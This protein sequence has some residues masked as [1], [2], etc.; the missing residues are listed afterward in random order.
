M[1]Y[2]GLTK[3]AA[4]HFSSVPLAQ[5]SQAVTGDSELFVCNLFPGELLTPVNEKDGST[6]FYDKAGELVAV[7][8]SDGNVFAKIDGHIYI[9]E[10][11]ADDKKSDEDTKPEKKG[12]VDV[13]A[14][15]AQVCES[16]TEDVFVLEASDGQCIADG[17]VV[18][19]GAQTENAARNM[20]GGLEVFGSCVCESRPEDVF[21][22]DDPWG[23]CIDNTG[24]GGTAVAAA[25][26]KEEPKAKGAD[27]GTVAKKADAGDAAAVPV[28]EAGKPVDRPPTVPRKPEG[29][30]DEKCDG[31]VGEAPLSLED[32]MQGGA[33]S[34][35]AAAPAADDGAQAAPVAEEQ[36]NPY[37]ATVQI[38]VAPIDIATQF[39]DSGAQFC[40]A[41]AFPQGGSLEFAT[42]VCDGDASAFDVGCRRF[43]SS[44]AD[45]VE[46]YAPPPLA[47][48]RAVEPGYEDAPV[49]EPIL[50]A[51]A[52]KGDGSRVVDRAAD[53]GKP[54][55]VRRRVTPEGP[56]HASKVSAKTFIGSE[57][58]ALQDSPSF[59]EY[60]MARIGSPVQEAMGAV[61]ALAVQAG[62]NHKKE[63]APLAYVGYHGGQGGGRDGGK[64]GRDGERDEGYGGEGI[65]EDLFIPA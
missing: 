44:G 15:A 16:K 13:A 63:V 62:S 28:A 23:Q 27:D 20:F 50:V 19:V 65:Q 10:V 42:T 58:P 31:A 57:E 48:D 17:D 9:Y 53:E 45:A 36:E 61:F 4:Q 25:P 3:F 12:K 24:S 11:A 51:G 47:S 56:I 46:E 2:S 5:S 49:A 33:D 1:S 52:G 59:F 40:A 54:K 55:P 60:A 29:T 7:V 21:N 38:P 39:V 26:K 35:G 41:Q 32:D 43:V 64:N 8:D 6:S 30:A 22:P 14:H 18:N 37:A 34:S